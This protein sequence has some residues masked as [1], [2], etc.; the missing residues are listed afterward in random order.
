LRPTVGHDR[1]MAIEPRPADRDLVDGVSDARRLQAVEASGLLDRAGIEAFDKLAALAAKVLRT[2]MAFITV[3][4]EHRSWWVSCVGIDA[5]TPADRH[6]TVPESFC[7]YVV[8]DQAPVIIDDARSHPRTL[9]NPSVNALGVRAWAGYPLRGPGGQTL[10]SFCVADTQPHAWTDQ[11]V[12]IVGALADA[13]SAQVAV[14][15]SARAEVAALEAAEHERQLGRRAAT[16]IHHLASTAVEM[17]SADTYEELAA[18]VVT[19]GLALLDADAGALVVRERDDTLRVVMGDSFDG[20]VPPDLT[21]RSLDDVLP[22]RY[23]A[24]SGERILLPTRAAGLAFSPEMDGVYQQSGRLAWAFIPLRTG[25]E[26][27]GSLV[28]SWNGERTLGA[29]ELALLDSFAAQCS[30]AVYRI[31]QLKA[32]EATALDSQ[33]L[34]ESLQRSLLTQPPTPEALRIAV[35][36][37]PAA[38]AAHVG[39]DWHDAFLTAD[40]ST[41]LVIGD[42]TGHDGLAAAAMAQIRNLLR[43]LTY[44]SRESPAVLLGRLDA[45]LAGLDVG[46]LATAVLVRIAPDGAAVS[47]GRHRLCW[48]NAGHLA[49]LLRRPDGT[50]E[51]LERPTNMMLGVYPDAPRTEH[52]IDIERGSM[53]LLYTDGLV[54]GRH[55]GLDEGIA[56]LMG[57]VADARPDD[58]DGLCD[59]VLAAGIV[60]DSRDDVA[61]LA[62]FC[63]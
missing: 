25:T 52:T 24:R 35:R 26:K 20:F 53:L 50:V 42:V 17:T 22:G 41:M 7:R 62:L 55:A 46:G 48:S 39:G 28:I 27:L 21:D 59:A 4:D 29:D 63:G 51:V 37:Q 43:G 54:E 60:T 36:Y 30:Q 6:T 14:L 57:V 58:P 38:E 45:A 11:E 32:L 3:V 15:A 44:H 9:D 49:P 34:S 1:W 33:R 8:A 18:I 5:A 31:Q 23:S 13:A 56:R 12:A 61:V 16:L 40:G 2:P 47:T 10:G 19:R